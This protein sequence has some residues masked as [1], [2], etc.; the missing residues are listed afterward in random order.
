MLANR[1]RVVCRQ[2]L[3]FLFNAYMSFYKTDN[4]IIKLV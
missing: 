3:D 4:F 2:R 1:L